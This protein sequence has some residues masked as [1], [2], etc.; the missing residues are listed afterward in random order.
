MDM[1]DL[2]HSLAAAAPA[3]EPRAGGFRAVGI[4]VAKLAAP[5][6]KKRGGGYLVR[7]KAAWPA[8]VAGTDWAAFAW[9]ATLGRDG[10]LKLH[11]VPSAALELQH[12]APLLIER[13]NSFL[14][15]AVITRLSLVQA[16]P[17]L[18]APA[19][20]PLRLSTADEASA[21]ERTLADIDDPE[22]RTALAGLGRAVLASQPSAPGIAPGAGTR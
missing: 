7:L 20:P 22:L 17:P 10:A 14:G 1:A 2:R 21:L 13:I 8:A 11:V 9:P 19:V 18:P 16:L 15:S 5:I 4:P 12:R 3:G 6:I